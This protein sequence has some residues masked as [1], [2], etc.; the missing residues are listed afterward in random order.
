MTWCG[1]TCSEITILVHC[2]SIGFIFYSLSTGSVLTRPNEVYGDKCDNLESF[3][4]THPVLNEK[5]LHV[6]GTKIPSLP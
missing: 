1:P 2:M 5:A 6:S 3:L 4:E